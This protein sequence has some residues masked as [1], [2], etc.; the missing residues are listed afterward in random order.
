MVVGQDIIA[1]PPYTPH[2]PTPEEIREQHRKAEEAIDLFEQEHAGAF[3]AYR[4]MYLLGGTSATVVG[5]DLQQ[6]D[7]K[8]T[9]GAGET[10]IVAAMNLHPSI[11]PVSEGLQGS[12]LNTGNFGAARRLVA[13][14]FLRPDWGSFASSLET[15][16]PPLAGSRLWYDD[17]HVPFLAE[18]VK[19]ADAIWITEIWDDASSHKASLQLPAVRDAIAKGRPL[20]AGFEISA[21]TRPV[22][23]PA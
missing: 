8:A 10:R 4:T 23:R 11:V 6:L 9:Q 12:A 21:E 22:T 17:R 18:D 20:I 16:V 7:F 2:A 15:I 19:D 1:P 14:T 13:D 5:K 3:N